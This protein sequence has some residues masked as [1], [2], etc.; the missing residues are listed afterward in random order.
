MMSSPQPRGFPTYRVALD[1]VQTPCG[2]ML[3][4]ATF[5]QFLAL[6][7]PTVQALSILANTA[8]QHACVAPNRLPHVIQF[9][10]LR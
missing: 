7:I 1:W 3:Q 4:P 5:D 10:V 8:G 2:P 6:D 9:T